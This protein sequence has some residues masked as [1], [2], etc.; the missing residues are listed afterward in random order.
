MPSA[1]S[2]ICPRILSRLWSSDSPSHLLFEK[3]RFTDY[4][5]L[6]S[7]VGN[8]NSVCSRLRTKLPI[9]R[10]RFSSPPRQVPRSACPVALS[11]HSCTFLPPCR[12][13]LPTETHQDHPSLGCHYYNWHPSFSVSAF[14]TASTTDSA[15]CAQVQT[16]PTDD[17]PVPHTNTPPH[18]ARGT[19]SNRVT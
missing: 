10:S 13:D 4:G 18:Y 12:P 5:H 11:L 2:E 16:S 8:P 19:F 6:G 3:L 1:G 7:L 14:C 15:S 17:V 9:A